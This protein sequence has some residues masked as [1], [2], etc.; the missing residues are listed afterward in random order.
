MNEQQLEDLL[1]ALATQTAAMMRLA[2]SNEALA[3]MIYQSMVGEIETT[4]IDS[5]VRTYLSD[6]PRG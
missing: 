6:K 2:E 5:P 1:A 3:A 4:T